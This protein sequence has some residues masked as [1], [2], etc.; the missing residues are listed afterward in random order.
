MNEIGEMDITEPKVDASLPPE[1][2]PGEV[3]F[4]KRVVMEPKAWRSRDLMDSSLV[5]GE[6]TEGEWDRTEEEDGY[7]VQ[8]KAIGEGQEAVYKA[9]DT[10]LERYV[11]IKTMKK[12]R[13]WGGVQEVKNKLPIIQKETAVTGGAAEHLNTVKVFGFQVST[14][15][16]G[17]EGEELGLMIME[18]L[19]ENYKRLDLLI[20][21]GELEAEEI[22]EIS[23]QL[24]NWVSTMGKRGIVN[25][26]LKPQNMMWDAETK[27]LKIYDLG[28]ANIMDDVKEGLISYTKKYA[29]VEFQKQ[30][31]FDDPRSGVWITAKIISEM[32]TGEDFL[33][34]FGIRQIQ[35]EFDSLY[36]E[37]LMEGDY[38]EKFR[39]GVKKYNNSFDLVNEIVSVM[40]IALSKEYQDRYDDCEEFMKELVP[41][42]ERLSESGK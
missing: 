17:Y 6:D 3:F 16:E 18:Y 15:F 32:F 12:R 40:D 29:P 5:D 23:K 34:Q 26:D 42:L 9:Y 30:G 36:E 31:I 38:A 22:V 28:G 41:R 21:S 39:S 11:A 7:W 4:V 19:P 35:F 8:R 37:S 14:D 27:M 10:R 25:R 1:M 2:D 24:L 20:H 13:G 33:D